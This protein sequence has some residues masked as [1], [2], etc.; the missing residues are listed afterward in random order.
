MCVCVCVCVCVCIHFSKFISRVDR[1]L[2]GAISLQYINY[3]F[4][5]VCWFYYCI[6]RATIGT[7]L[8]VSHLPITITS[9][10][11]NPYPM[12]YITHLSLSL[13]FPPS[14]LHVEVDVIGLLETDANR[15]YI[16]SHD[17]ASWLGE[18]LHM[19]TDYGPG[20]KDHTW[21]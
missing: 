16:G 19:Y 20:S 1:Y 14:F 7:P 2:S 13:P 11:F 6:T 9:W 21:G 8:I 15:P 10:I 12:C 17:I 5:T 4:E 3:S 18:R